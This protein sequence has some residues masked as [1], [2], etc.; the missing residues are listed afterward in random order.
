MHL[1]IGPVYTFKVSLYKPVGV[2]RKTT[3]MK[4]PLTPL[5]KL[6][7]CYGVFYEL[8][9]WK[10]MLFEGPSWKF[11]I[12]GPISLS[13]APIMKSHPFTGRLVS[14][15]Q[16]SQ[17]KSTSI[18]KKYAEKKNINHSGIRMDTSRCISFR[19]SIRKREYNGE[20]AGFKKKYLP[21][22]QLW[23][24]VNYQNNYI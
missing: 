23:L 2:I 18:L 20:S 1:S 17:H 3:E 11:W 21:I 14:S 10:Y 22:I 4:S 13:Q 8:L 12:R 6:L 19:F 15:Q 24:G 5:L 16:Y 7:L 9:C